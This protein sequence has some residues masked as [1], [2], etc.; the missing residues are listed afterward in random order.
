MKG[1]LAVLQVEQGV[2]NTDQHLLDA[3]LQTALDNFQHAEG[4]GM[5]YSR[6]EARRTLAHVRLRRGE[7]AEAER[8][9]AEALELVADTESRVSRLWLGPIYI[10]VVLAV[11]G[12]AEAS[13]KDAEGA[14]RLE[15][16]A[17][18]RA[19]A[20]SK[21]DLA[22]QLLVRYTDFV[23]GLQSPRFKREATRLAALLE[24]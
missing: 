16:A 2:L 11:S 22:K 13:A 3:A 5:L 9:C 14:G 21:R 23:A 15:E 7:L 8:L 24:S 1:N 17:E 20:E 10:E 18:Y 19:Q 6:F 4:L 12:S